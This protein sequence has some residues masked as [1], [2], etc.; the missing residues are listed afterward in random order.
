MEAEDTESSAIR[1]F[2]NSLWKAASRGRLPY[3]HLD[4]ACVQAK[5][6]ES[7]LI[8]AFKHRSRTSQGH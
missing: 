4:T 6:T 1:A 2:K 7:S 5:D 3:T 8:R